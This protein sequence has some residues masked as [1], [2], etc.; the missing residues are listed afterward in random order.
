MGVKLGALLVNATAL[1]EAED[2]ESAAVGQNRAGPSDKAVE[3]TAPGD[4]LVAGPRK[5]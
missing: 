5:R 2:L 4:E 3:P 1:G